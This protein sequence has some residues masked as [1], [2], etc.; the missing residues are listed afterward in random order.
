[1]PFGD[2]DKA[3]IKNFHQFKKYGSQR[4]LVKFSEKKL[5]KGRT[6]HSIGKDKKQ[7]AL[8]KVMRAADRSTRV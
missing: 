4:I 8:I 1:M 6:G 5:E 7:E 3:L 2:E